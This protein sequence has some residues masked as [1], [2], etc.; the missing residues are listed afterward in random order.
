MQDDDFSF[1]AFNDELGIYEGYPT[2]GGVLKILEN[3]H[4]DMDDWRKLN[5]LFAHPTPHFKCETK[6][7]AI[8]VNNLIKSIGWKVGT[9]LATNSE[10]SLK[11]ITGQE[12][13]ILMLSIQ[14]NIKIIS[15]HTGVGPHFLGFANTMSNRSTAESMGE[16][17]EVT[18]FA[19]IASWKR[20][21]VDLFNK[22]I[23]MRNKKLNQKITENILHPKLV[24]LTDRQWQHIKDIYMNA[25]KEGLISKELFL[26][27]IPDLDVD[28]EM[29]KIKAEEAEATKKKEETFVPAKE[30]DEEDDE[31]E[32][33]ND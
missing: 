15:A 6:E 24:P 20:F 8:A 10:F 22:A 27:S 23:R 33:N 11:G 13:N 3:L 1:I 18:L 9:A 28:A 30:T 7:E 31:Q 29:D 2:V 16:P 21:Y 14:S 26:S 25:A 12:G 4:K 19:E 32:E 17:T 5:H